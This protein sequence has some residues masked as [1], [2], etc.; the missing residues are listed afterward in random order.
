MKL[1]RITLKRCKLKRLTH[2]NVPRTLACHRPKPNY[3]RKEEGKLF[4][5]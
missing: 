2:V 1:K 5:S 4:G 3:W